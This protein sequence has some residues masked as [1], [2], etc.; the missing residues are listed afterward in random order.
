MIKEA[1]LKLA[2][3]EDLTYGMAEEVMNEIMRARRLLYRCRHI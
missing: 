2:K 1:I 3:K